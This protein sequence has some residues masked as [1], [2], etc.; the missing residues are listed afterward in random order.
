MKQVFISN[1]A[2]QIS[3]EEMY[4]EYVIWSEGGTHLAYHSKHFPSTGIHG[5]LSELKSLWQFAAINWLM[6]GARALEA[7]DGSLLNMTY[8]KER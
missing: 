2:L 5:T 4:R 1:E 6:E 3:A 7:R 8:I